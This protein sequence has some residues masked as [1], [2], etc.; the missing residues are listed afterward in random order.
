MPMLAIVGRVGL[1]VP[2]IPNEV[3]GLPAGIVFVTV[4]APVL[5]MSGG[6]PQVDRWVRSVD[7]CPFDDQGLAVDQLWVREL[8]DVET[9]VKTGLAHTDRYADIA[10]DG[11][12]NQRTCDRP[13]SHCP[14]QELIYART[15]RPCR[16][17]VCAHGSPV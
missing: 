17:G 9:A 12:R 3:D 10:S 14:L 6:Y 13:P 11:G 4:L 8:A 5:F 2:T 1:L 7:L 15:P 16:C